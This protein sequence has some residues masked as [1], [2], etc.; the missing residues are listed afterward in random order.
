MARV[1]RLQKKKEAKMLGKIF[2][3]LD[4]WKTAIAY[5]LLNIPVLSD[6]PMLMSAIQAARENPSKENLTLVLIQAIM[7]LGVADRI[8][9]NVAQ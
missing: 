7:A 4:G 1:L 9:K 8:R 3:K 6:Q 2:S 5:L